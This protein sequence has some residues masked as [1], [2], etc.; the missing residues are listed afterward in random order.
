MKSIFDFDGDIQQYA[1]DALFAEWRV[2]PTRSLE[3][4]VYLATVCA[5]KVAE[6]LSDFPL[7]VRVG[8]KTLTVNMNHH[9]GLGCGDTIGIHIG[10]NTHRREYL[11]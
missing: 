2:N 6:D 11:Q 10:D 5:C 7:T 4:C 1:G 9:S 8:A 3:E